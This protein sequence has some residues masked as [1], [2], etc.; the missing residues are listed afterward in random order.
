MGAIRLRGLGRVLSAAVVVVVAVGGV[1][2][3]SSGDGEAGATASASETQGSGGASGGASASGGATAEATGGGSAPASVSPES[4]SDP[5]IQYTVASIPEGLDQAKT[6][7]LSAYIAYSQATWAAY[8]EQE[9]LSEVEST[10][11][12]EALASYTESYNGFVSAGQHLEGSYGVEVSSVDVAPDGMTATVASCVD[13]RMVTVIDS[14]GQ[15]LTQ[16]TAK[17]T[18]SFVV[19]LVPGSKGWVVAET[20][21]T[22]S[23][24]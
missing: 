15:D 21:E 4:L 7:V 14:T 1:S 13:Q 5:A 18:V 8:R 11:T 20:T 16:E 2:A 10:A 12:G 17:R 24:C 22:G 3:C 19:T 23:G 6:E 9:G